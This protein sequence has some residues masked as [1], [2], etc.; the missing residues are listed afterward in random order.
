M[1]ALWKLRWIFHPIENNQSDMGTSQ[2]RST[3]SAEIWERGKAFGIPG[4]AVDGMDRAC[5]QGSKGERAVKTTGV[6]ATAPIFWKFQGH[7]ELSR[8]LYVGPCEIR[9]P[10]KKCRKCAMERDPPSNRF[11]R[12]ILLE[13]KHASED[14]SRRSTKR[15]KEIV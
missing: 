11:C 8:T 5:S 14:D 6:R 4:E 15:I 1:A 9:A 2:Q 13:H 7:I 3:S 10:A 12:N